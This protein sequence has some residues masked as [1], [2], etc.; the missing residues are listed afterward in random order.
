[1][2]RSKNVYQGVQL[3]RIHR[4]ELDDNKLRELSRHEARL[5]VDLKTV[6]RARMVMKKSM[7]HDKQLFM[8]GGTQTNT[9]ITTSSYLRPTAHPPTHHSRFVPDT[10][11]K[12]VSISEQGGIDSNVVA[13]SSKPSPH[14]STELVE[15]NHTVSIYD[16]FL[17]SSTGLPSTKRQSDS[18]KKKATP[19]PK[20]TS[21]DTPENKE[22][23]AAS[24]DKEEVQNHVKDA[25]VFVKR[26]SIWETLS[27]PKHV[28]MT[29]LKRTQV[30][31]EFSQPAS[32]KL[33]QKSSQKGK[34][35]QPTQHARGR[36]SNGQS[37]NYKGKEL[38]KKLKNDT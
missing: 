11:S 14:P 20:D 12:R 8:K 10:K 26:S 7:D 29:K 23:S 13:N 1:M 33:T 9:K 6:E 32:T 24:R 31:R 15:Q 21:A 4:S 2:S 5:E 27:V 38:D 34:P 18:A 30:E 36:H 28:S 25:D 37:V 17:E 16:R 19:S 3:N 22:G 35:N